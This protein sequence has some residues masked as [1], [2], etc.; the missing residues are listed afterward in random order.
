[1]HWKKVEAMMPINDTLK[2]KFRTKKI[3]AAWFVSNCNAPSGRDS[4]AEQ[5]QYEL[6]KYNM[7]VDI[8]GRCG[9]MKCPR[10]SMEECLRKLETDYYFYLAFE[11]SIA[12]DYVTEKLL[13]AL[14]HYTVPVVY[15][16]ANY[17]RFM[18]EGIYL[19]AQKSRIK[20]L[21]QEMVDIINDKQKYYDFFSEDYV[22]EKLLRALNNNAVPIVYGGADY[23]RFMPDGIYLD[24]KLLD[25]KTLSEKMYELINNPEKYAEYFK[26]KNHY[27]YHKKSESVDTDPY[28]LFCT[29]L[30]NEEMTQS[31]RELYVKRLKAE[32]SEKYERDVHVYGDCGMFTCNREKQDCDQLLKRDYYFYLSFENAFSEDYVTEKLMH[33]VQ[34]NV[35]PIVYGGANYSRFLPHRSY[36]NAREYKVAE[37]AK[38]ID[39][40][41]REPS[42]YAEFFRWK[43]YYSYHRTTDLEETN[44]YCK[45]CA[46]LNDEKL[47]KTTSVCN[48]FSDFW[49]V[50]KTC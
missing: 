34:N 32:L 25:A 22:T 48:E 6:A 23:T 12:E 24:A 30:N 19:S 17:T 15:G 41:I 35:V 40:L 9:T 4:I 31:K 14:Q 43:K 21:A 45:M 38:L 36:I 20:H 2:A 28:C 37:L 16:G 33:A 50:N 47:M 39:Q 11:N 7:T 1:M 5:L 29:T 18:P 49:E 8:Y 46:A 27:T 44:E 3:A 42:T 26:W 13:H 10:D